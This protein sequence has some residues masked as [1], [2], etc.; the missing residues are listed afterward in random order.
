MSLGRFAIHRNDAM[1]KVS[2]LV[3]S[4]MVLG[5]IWCLIPNY[6]RYVVPDGFR[7]F[8]NIVQDSSADP[9]KQHLFILTID[10]PPSG[11]IEVKSLKSLR[12]WCVFDASYVSGEALPVYF[13]GDNEN[14][15]VGLWIMGPPAGDRLYA[16]VGS[17]RE[18]RKYVEKN[19]NR[20]YQSPPLDPN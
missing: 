15:G 1:K 13:P 14:K 6:V 8:I 16:F 3:V 2:S 10:V 7:G 17:H 9:V 4:V 12:A 18:M 11:K 20:I 5:L 19:G